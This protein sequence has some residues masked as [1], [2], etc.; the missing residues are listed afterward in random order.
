MKRKI[1]LNEEEDTTSKSPPPPPTSTILSIFD[2]PSADLTSLTSWHTFLNKTSHR[3]KLGKIVHYGSRGAVGLI[4]NIVSLLSNQQSVVAIGLLSLQSKFR[5]V[6][7]N[8][9]TARRCVRWL[10]GTGLMLQLMEGWDTLSLRL[11]AIKCFMLTWV[12]SDHFRWLQQNKLIGG[13]QAFTRNFGF[14]FACASWGLAAYHHTSILMAYKAPNRETA[15]E[16]KKRIANQNKTKRA[17]VR[18]TL[19]CISAAHISQLFIHSEA[20]CGFFGSFT[21]AFDMYELFPREE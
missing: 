2:K 18:N 11:K 13:D 3:D 9:M 4:G 12:L 16:T 1:Q 15:S 17:I 19:G 7:K 14:S 20:I 5:T 21:A 8:V 10:T 6:F